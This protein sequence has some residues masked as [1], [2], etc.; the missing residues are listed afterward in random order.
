MGSAQAKQFAEQRY[1]PLLITYFKALKKTNRGISNSHDQYCSKFNLSPI[2]P[3]GKGLKG[4][5]R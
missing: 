3:V 2:A 1:W 5:L 4:T